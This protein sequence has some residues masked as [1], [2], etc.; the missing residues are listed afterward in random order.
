[1]SS[2]CGQAWWSLPIPKGNSFYLAFV[3][4]AD[5][6]GPTLPPPAT[7]GLIVTPAV[8]TYRFPSRFEARSRPNGARCRPRRFRVESSVGFVGN[9]YRIGLL[10]RVQQKGNGVLSRQVLGLRSGGAVGARRITNEM[11][12]RGLVFAPVR[13]RLRWATAARAG[14]IRTRQRSRSLESAA[15]E[16]L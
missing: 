3:T 8:S 9:P 14:T 11:I 4:G 15:G 6:S 13:G 16:V 2:D 5:R 1:M 10:G 12:S 7:A